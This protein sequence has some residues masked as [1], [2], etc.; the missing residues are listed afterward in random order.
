MRAPGGYVTVVEP[1][2]PL[3]EIDTVGCK[4]CGALIYVKPATACTTYLIP[5]PTPGRYVEEPGAFCARCF[6]PICLPCL[7][8]GTCT[9]FLKLLEASESRD[10]LRRA[11]GL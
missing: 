9:P 2:Q 10:R 8:A 6:G 11:A 4:H 5:T 7:E 3:V 1:D